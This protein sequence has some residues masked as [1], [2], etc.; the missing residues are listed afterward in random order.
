MKKLSDNRAGVEQAGNSSRY[1]PASELDFKRYAKCVAELL[2]SP[3][4]EAQELLAR[5]YGYEHLHELQQALKAPGVAGPFEDKMH[6][7]SAKES[8]KALEIRLKRHDRLGHAYLHWL[9]GQSS[10]R[11]DDSGDMLLWDVGLFSSP[12]KQ[13]AAAKQVQDF[14]NT[15]TGFSADGFPF[16]FNGIL[17]SRYKAG[18]PMD[19]AAFDKAQSELPLDS[20]FILH[21]DRQ[22][23]VLRKRRAPELLT[24]MVRQIDPEFPE[25]EAEVPLPPEWF[26][27][28]GGESPGL[29]QPSFDEMLVGFLLERYEPGNLEGGDQAEW[30]LALLALAEPNADNIARSRLCR[31]VENLAALLPRWRLSLR[32]QL[33]KFLKGDEFD[34]ENGSYIGP[35]KVIEAS[36]KGYLMQVLLRKVYTDAEF[37]RWEL[38]AVLFKKGALECWE[39]AGALYGDYIQPTDPENDTYPSPGE[40]LSCFDDYGEHDLMQVWQVLQGLYL[41][42]AGYANYAEWVNDMDSGALANVL[43]WVAPEFRGTDVSRHLFD[44]LGQAFEDG[45]VNFDTFW[46]SWLRPEEEDADNYDEEF[47]PGLGPLFISLPGTGLLGFSIWEGDTDAPTVRLLREGGH[48]LASGRSLRRYPGRFPDPPKRGLGNRLLEVLKPLPD[49]FIFYDAEEVTDE[50]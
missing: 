4:Q 7:L 33:A 43:P 6:L 36:S 2:S 47:L 31:Q 48:R 35:V 21:P 15:R 13:K 39:P 23:E 16:G 24:E 49:D 27:F 18:L 37:I 26:D 1:R 3:L 29:L 22:L 9:R 41:P 10:R 25:A 42:R 11:E 44:L 30:D 14:R 50:G 38:Q 19:E 8:C 40:L 45:P 12:K 28:T 5:A 46:R 34:D 17:H 32:L 20:D